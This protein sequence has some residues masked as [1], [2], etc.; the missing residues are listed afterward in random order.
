MDYKVINL[1]VKDFAFYDERT[2]T[3]NKMI[4]PTEKKNETKYI[5]YISRY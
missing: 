1:G 2:K 5:Y 3:K 4:T